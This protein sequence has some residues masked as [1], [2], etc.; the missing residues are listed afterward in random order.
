MECLKDI[1]HILSALNSQPV[2]DTYSLYSRRDS[3]ALKMEAI[4]SSETSVLTI[5]T[6]SSISLNVQKTNKMKLRLKIYIQFKY[7]IP[8]YVVRFK[9]YIP[10]YVV[11]FQFG[12]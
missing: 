10:N 12:L 1:L 11:R 4:H 7:Y 8:N 6:L 5:T 2:A 3:P 9:Y